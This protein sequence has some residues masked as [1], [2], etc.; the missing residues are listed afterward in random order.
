MSIT[1]LFIFVK[2]TSVLSLGLKYFK[3]PL[4]KRYMFPLFEK[5]PALANVSKSYNFLKTGALP[6]LSI[7]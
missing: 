5:K 1:S 4:S 7:S 2:V 6:T 3:V